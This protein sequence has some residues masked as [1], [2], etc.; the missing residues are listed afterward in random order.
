MKKIIRKI[1]FSSLCLAV[2]SIPVHAMK[3]KNESVDTNPS[4]HKKQNRNESEESSMSLIPALL[5]NN[6]HILA[7]R[8]T[9]SVKALLDYQNRKYTEHLLNYLQP[10]MT[11][12]TRAAF[13]EFIKQP[14]ILGI[15]FLKE[16]I[17]PANKV[18]YFIALQFFRCM[19]VTKK[20]FMANDEKKFG[21]AS[22]D[23]LDF[24][25]IQL[26]IIEL[27]TFFSPSSNFISLS[28]HEVIGLNNLFEFE[29]DLNDYTQLQSKF[30]AAH[31]ILYPFTKGI[32]KIEES[33]IDR[34][35]EVIKNDTNEKRLEVALC[36]FGNMAR[37]PGNYGGKFDLGIACFVRLYFKYKD[38]LIIMQNISFCLRNLII[39]CEPEKL[40]SYSSFLHNLFLYPNETVV[41]WAARGYGARLSRE[42]NSYAAISLKEFYPLLTSEYESV[43]MWALSY[44]SSFL[45]DFK[46]RPVHAI[47]GLEI[48]NK[49]LSTL[50]MHDERE[51]KSGKII[52]AALWALGSIVVRQ[53]I[54]GQEGENLG[55]SLSIFRYPAHSPKPKQ[56]PK[57]IL[58]YIDFENMKIFPEN[59][60]K[61]ILF[62]CRCLA[63][64]TSSGGVNKIPLNQEI[65]KKVVSLIDAKNEKITVWSLCFL[66]TLSTNTLEYNAEI[67]T[68]IGSED[69]LRKLVH[70]LDHHSEDAKILE[71][72]LWS[73]H[74]IAW[75]EKF[76]N[77]LREL[78]CTTALLTKFSSHPSDKVREAAYL[79]F[80]VLATARDN[81]DDFFKEMMPSLENI[82]R[83][84]NSQL[85]LAAVRSLN[86]RVTSTTCDCKENRIAIGKY[87]DVMKLLVGLLSTNELLL[88]ESVCWCLGNLALDINNSASLCPLILDEMILLLNKDNPIYLNKSAL[89]V[90]EG[91]CFC[92]CNMLIESDVNDEMMSKNY[93]GKELFFLSLLD[94]DLAGEYKYSAKVIEAALWALHKIVTKADACSMNF[95]KS[96]FQS[97][98]GFEKVVSLFDYPSE[99]VVAG[100]CWCFGKM[101]PWNEE[102][103]HKLESGRLLL[104]L[105]KG[106]SSF[107]NERLVVLILRCINTICV[108]E[109]GDA[110]KR[111]MNALTTPTL[112]NLLRKNSTNQAVE[113]WCGCIASLLS[114]DENIQLFN[115]Q[116]GR[117]FLRSLDV[118]KCSSND[119]EAILLIYSK[120]LQDNGLL[121]QITQD[122]INF[123]VEMKDHAVVKIS[124][125]SAKK[126]LSEHSQD[127]IKDKAQ[128]SMQTITTTITTSDA[129]TV[130]HVLS[131]KPSNAQPTDEVARLAKIVEQAEYCLKILFD[132]GIHKGDIK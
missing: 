16:K 53:E 54:E 58:K 132:A 50:C 1:I 64:F 100:A 61:I 84:Q 89:K 115:Q 117:S 123:I 11:P 10:Q 23:F 93:G 68:L 65:L 102:Q 131:Q 26:I 12:E 37:T 32:E 7:Q 66:G 18:A 129:T 81:L 35:I 3:R 87:E 24:R 36:L 105:L 71:A 106:F 98:K 33:H 82:S 20:E 94:R 103:S 128:Q 124:E 43:V 77:S 99:K 116:D 19:Q 25:N 27:F 114:L 49:V 45:A 88:L 41:A 112:L 107:E 130:S 52:E 120:L 104:N 42:L 15:N 119:I 75:C 125:I 108:N 101:V 110:Q 96:V 46:L 83:N 4:A 113:T 48:Y 79:C 59:G 122:D 91:V 72:A 34:I 70:C 47:D 21:D 95:I 118:K 62:A 38:S 30:K 17:A 8:N 69:I 14:E 63:N 2:F 6:P 60:E 22:M 73:L 57:E 28:E 56:I 9:E 44:C 80:G 86:T 13:D 76:Q 126:N 5:N 51:I 74:K 31:Q 29:I 127:I 121:L 55:P 111:Y 92:I 97:N 39:F 78:G 109:C 85:R 40:E 67:R 90:V